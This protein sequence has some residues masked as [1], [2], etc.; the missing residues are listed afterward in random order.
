MVA[1]ALISSYATYRFTRRMQLEAEWRKDKLVYYSQL[2]ESITEAMSMPGDFENVYKKYAH[3]H[4]VVSLVAPQDV[5]NIV[6]EF[7]YAQEVSRKQQ[8]GNEEEDKFVTDQKRLLKQLVLAMRKDLR[9]KPNDDPDTFKYRLRSPL[10]M[11]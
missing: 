7:Y 8:E 2:I 9:I 1:V 11:D 10:H 5:A 6:F 3:S 4:N